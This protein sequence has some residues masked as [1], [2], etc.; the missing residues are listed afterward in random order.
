MRPTRPSSRRGAVDRFTLLV[1]AI[2][3][4]TWVVAILDRVQTPVVPPIA[5]EGLRVLI[6][7]DICKRPTLPLRQ[8]MIFSDPMI[9]DY[10]DSHCVKEDGAP[11]FR[12]LDSEA[13]MRDA[14]PHWQEAMKR[15]R[16]SLPWI[17]VSNSAKGGTE[18]PLPATADDTLALLK[19]WGGP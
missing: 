1:L 2:V 4:A 3:A 13:D 17:V 15:E 11:A 18:G 8:R 7:E 5:G 9:R 19:K 10:L 12:I 16:K 6:V 14:A